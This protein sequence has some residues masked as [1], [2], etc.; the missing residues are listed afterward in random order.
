MNALLKPNRF[1]G[2]PLVDPA[3]FRRCMRTV[4]GAVAV[5]T[6]GEP[7]H[8]TGLTAT[9]VC[10]LTDAPPT[11]LACVNGS[12]SAHPVIRRT[13][14]FAVNILSEADL[15]VAG[16]FAGRDGIKGED[17]FEGL[18]CTQAPGGAPI[19]AEA[20]ASFDCVLE[21]EHRYGTHSVFIGRVLSAATD[22]TRPPLLYLDGRFG[23]FAEDA[24]RAAS[25]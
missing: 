14:R 25:R 5:I 15:D 16:R 7:G 9:A 20:L 23:T 6:C 8:R 13:G 3:E 12:A 4:P 22:P 1:E 11:L 18:A 24:A 19:L 10:S 17:R 2:T 21:A